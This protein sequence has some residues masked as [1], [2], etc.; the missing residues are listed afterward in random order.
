VLEILNHITYESRFY[1]GY[2]KINEK[3]YLFNFPNLRELNVPPTYSGIE[4]TAEEY[5][6]DLNDIV[7]QEF[8]SVPSILE[9]CPTNDTAGLMDFTLDGFLELLKDLNGLVNFID[10]K[11]TLRGCILFWHKELGIAKEKKVVN[12]FLNKLL[13]IHYKNGGKQS[14][15][16]STVDDSLETL[17]QLPYLKVSE[18]GKIEILHN[19]LAKTIM[20]DFTVKNIAGQVMFFNKKRGHYAGFLD[21]LPSIVTTYVD[22]AKSSEVNE[23]VKYIERKL[24][25]WQEDEDVPFVE[26]SKKYIAFQ[27][28]VY[29]LEKHKFIKH[30]SDYHVTS[31]IEQKGRW[32]EEDKR[33]GERYLKRIAGNDIDKYNLLLDFVSAAISPNKIKYKKFFTF[34]GEPSVGKSNFVKYVGELLYGKAI[35]G[36]SFDSISQQNQFALEGLINTPYNISD[37]SSS[38][39]GFQSNTLKKFVG[40]N[41]INVKR[42]YKSDITMSPNFLQVFTSN[43]A[44]KFKNSDHREAIEIRQIIIELTERLSDEDD[45]FWD[46][47]HSD[48][49]KIG[50]V[51]L[52]L[53]NLIE[54]EK[55]PK[56]EWFRTTERSKQLN[57]ESLQD[58]V[59]EFLETVDYKSYHTKPMP[60]MYSDYVDSQAGSYPVS[61]E[62]FTRRVKQQTGAEIKVASLKT[63]AFGKAVSLRCVFF[64]KDLLT[65]SKAPPNIQTLNHS[66]FENEK[67]DNQYLDDDDDPLPF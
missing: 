15:D 55:R 19:E 65:E 8:K 18:R 5:K 28:K 53:E 63:G 54:M 23:V 60:D 34:T 14:Q 47:V 21:M 10:I 20:N 49:C 50:I 12:D 16:L 1:A 6:G 67:L 30:S 61:K 40:E 4:Y 57:K 48:S 45:E 59:D 39:D 35:T 42:K 31:R 64:P 24:P 26:L 38:L 46:M 51:G 11:K 32:D 52:A 41:T 3:Q 56:G 33:K 9:Q 17:K 27:D 13:A 29:D 37:D 22:F 62:T 2:H 36:E 25:T 44:L 58:S 7:L 66:S 43:N